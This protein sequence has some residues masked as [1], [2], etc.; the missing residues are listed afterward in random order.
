MLCSVRVCPA[1]VTQNV[2]N[3]NEFP[4]VFYDDHMWPEITRLFHAGVV[5]FVLV[6][7]LLPSRRAWEVHAAL[8]PCIIAHWAA[9]NNECVLSQLEARLRGV[10]THRTFM[11][12]LVGPIYDPGHAQPWVI[13]GMV[14]LCLSS[15]GRIARHGS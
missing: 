2:T 1:Q 10:K 3:P 14:A 12:D 15:V 5:A 6:G 4:N 9:N 13:A 7:P 8:V 11:Q